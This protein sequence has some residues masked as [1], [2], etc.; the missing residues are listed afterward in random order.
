MSNTNSI[1]DAVAVFL[2]RGITAEF[3]GEAEPAVLLAKK[4]RKYPTAPISFYRGLQESPKTLT[5]TY[6]T[7]DFLT[8]EYKHQILPALYRF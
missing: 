2:E 7:P 5:A 1:D 8:T 4:K 3:T 6:P